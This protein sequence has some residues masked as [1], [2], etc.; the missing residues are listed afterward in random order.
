MYENTSGTLV[1]A[2]LR[3]SDLDPEDVY[4]LLW[5]SE[6]DEKDADEVYDMLT[7]DETKESAHADTPLHSGDDDPI[8]IVA[9][10]DISELEIIAAKQTIISAGGDITGLNFFGQNV[11]SDDV[12]IIQAQGDISLYSETQDTD[13]GLVN[14]GPGLFLVQAGGDIDLWTSNGI[15]VV[16]DAYYV[17]LGEEDSALAVIA[18][19]YQEI[20]SVEN[21]GL[22]FAE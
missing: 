21:L 13:S 12:T 1:R 8:T 9:V 6:D 4:Y 10:G 17:A 22:V 14:G 19:L 16:G 3:M 2:S 11:D 15:Q 7:E 5:E 20:V 18:G